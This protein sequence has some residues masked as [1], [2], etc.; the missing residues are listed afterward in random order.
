MFNSQL[1]SRRNTDRKVD[2]R[3][4]PDAESPRAQMRRLKVYLDQDPNMAPGD[5]IDDC[6]D[7]L[8]YL[9]E[10]MYRKIFTGTT[11]AE[12]LQLDADDPEAIDWLISVH[13]AESSAF[14]TRK[15]R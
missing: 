4:S 8:D 6:P 12:Y 2:F 10:Y 15:N 13:E 7:A 3:P 5:D 9:R 14:Q 1:F 11:H